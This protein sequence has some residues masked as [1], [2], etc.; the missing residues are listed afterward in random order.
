MGPDYKVDIGSS[1]Y[2]PIRGTFSAEYIAIERD[3]LKFKEPR[4]KTWNFT[5]TAVRI[6]G[7]R[8]WALYRKSIDV[9]DIHFDTPRLR[10]YLD[11]HLDSQQIH[12]PSTLPQ[13]HL[14]KLRH[15]LRI[16][17]L[18]LTNGEIIFEE[19]ARDGARPGSF[20]FADLS[21]VIT[22]LT[23][24]PGQMEIPCTVDVRTRLADSGAMHGRLEYNMASDSV[25]MDV[26]G[27]IGKMDVTT[28]NG[29]LVDLSGIHVTSGTIDSTWFD[30]HVVDDL[31]TGK[32]QC[33]YRNVQFELVD[34]S[35][36]EQDLKDAL[37]TLVFQN[38]SREANPEEHDEPPM[39]ASVHR[40]R[41]PYEN[42][43]KLIWL[44][45]RDGLLKTL[46]V[47]D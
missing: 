21:A 28:L 9:S 14:R 39:T 20:T 33:L 27:E 32:V 8:H 45:V 36:H 34:K 31:A 42:V 46:D 40:R 24:D 47:V 29:L 12:R 15:P 3:T 41:Q 11:R 38:D 5:A 16:A 10:V 37:A 2:N 43:L 6:E 30:L 1:H 7:I 19:R 35:S 44:S 23:N 26:K 22:N 18:S 25:T 17:N 4:R 13:E